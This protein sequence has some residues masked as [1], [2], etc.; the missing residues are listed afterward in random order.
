[1]SIHLRTGECLYFHL[2]L[3]CVIV[4]SFVFERDS[5][6]ADVGTGDC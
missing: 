3:G 2:Y 1:M 5:F 4:L 6:E